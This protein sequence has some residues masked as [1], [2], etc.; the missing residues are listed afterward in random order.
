MEDRR[1][2]GANSCNSGDGTDQRVQSLMFMMMITNIFLFTDCP[3]YTLLIHRLLS[4]HSSSYSHIHF[5]TT[6]SISKTTQ[7][8]SSLV[9]SAIFN[10]ILYLDINTIVFIIISS[11][12][13][14]K[15]ILYHFLLHFSFSTSSLLLLIL[16]NICFVSTSPFSTHN[17]PFST[18]RSLKKKK[19]E[20]KRWYNKKNIFTPYTCLTLIT[21]FR[22]VYPLHS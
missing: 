21:P 12:L 16:L 7:R 13:F 15:F 18:I 17:P 20:N 9:L 22:C 1:S 3:L 8:R 10:T 2:V 6:L 11:F 19:E 5:L 4:L 14:T